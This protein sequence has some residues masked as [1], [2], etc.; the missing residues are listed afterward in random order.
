[1]TT[2]ELQAGDTVYARSS[3]MVGIMDNQ[4]SI[5]MAIRGDKLKVVSVNGTS[6]EVHPITQPGNVFWASRHQLMAPGEL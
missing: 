4:P 3:I 1:M 2:P 5:T 6:I